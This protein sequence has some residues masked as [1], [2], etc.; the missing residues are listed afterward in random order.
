MGDDR[1]GSL[2][3]ATRT[4]EDWTPWLVLAD[5]LGERGDPRAALVRAHHRL[6]EGGLPDADRDVLANWIIA[7]E[8]A[9]EWPNSLPK[10]PPGVSVRWVRGF[11]H[12]IFL[13][14]L[15][16]DVVAYLNALQAHPFGRG[17]N[18]LRLMVRRPAVAAFGRLV[19]ARFAPHV[20]HWSFAQQALGPAHAR[21][22]AAA[23]P[24]LRSLDVSA[25]AL[26]DGGMMTLANTPWSDLEALHL[27]SNGIGT[28]G[29]HALAAANWPRLET[30][31]IMAAP[32]GETEATALA[33]AV[34]A[35]HLGFLQLPNCG[36]GAAIEA[37]IPAP[38]PALHTLGLAFNALGDAGLAKLS[39][40]QLPN[41]R[42]LAVMGNRIRDR[43]ARHFADQPWTTLRKVDLSQNP[44]IG[45][46]ARQALGTLPFE[47]LV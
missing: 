26:G 4:A 11:V 33:S 1:I 6:A 19:E 25:N 35:N 5:A 24:T 18:H 37:L 13:R 41:L 31:L 16:D 47:V 27:G 36:L 2:L 7:T 43:G 46:E 39:P 29:I 12:Q 9:S 38:R 3:A 14:R 28:E 21:V 30:L 15:A 42:R 34:Y 45:E 32:I 20:L 10:A 40:E 8:G 23:L 44:D 17:L 22:L